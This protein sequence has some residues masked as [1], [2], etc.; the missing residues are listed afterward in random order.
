MTR[1]GRLARAAL[2]HA[3]RGLAVFPLGPGSK[4]PAVEDW[5]HAATTDP[6]QI[7]G[8]WSEA[9]YNI[10]VATGPSNLLVIDL[11]CPKSPS[12][13]VPAPWDAAGT[14]CG[15]DVLDQLVA[16]ADQRLPRTWTVSTASGGQHLYFR[17]ADGRTLGNTAGRLGWKIDTRGQG[18]YVVAAGSVVRG[19]WYRAELIRRPQPPPQWL[20]DALTAE[21]ESP[22][23]NS[24]APVGERRLG[25]AYGLK[26][27]QGQLEKLLACTEG[28]RNDNLNAS[29]YALGRVAAA[30]A[31]TPQMIRDELVSAAQ[32]I[33]LGR[34][35][36]E[37]TIE[38]GL[39][40]G[41]RNPWHR[42]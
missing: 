19:Q 16:A 42:R 39:S 6:E 26:A 14:S 9:A 1:P 34:R 36:A 37:R 8:W 38:S 11:D 31:L 20:V 29:A 17:Q 18:G 2:W 4:R 27:L 25:P 32:R 28:S 13:A 22:R 23:T 33:G 10:G 40:A 15:R 24:T 21:P 30:G 41:L 3:A 7:E 12:E 35:E 5:P